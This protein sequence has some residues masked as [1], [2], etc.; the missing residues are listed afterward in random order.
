MH[1]EMHLP[2]KRL[3][4]LKCEQFF[5]HLVRSCGIERVKLEAAPLLKLWYFAYHECYGGDIDVFE[6]SVLKPRVLSLMRRRPII[7]NKI[8]RTEDRVMAHSKS[9]KTDN[10]RV[11]KQNFM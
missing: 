5:W 9:K 4:C 11:A 3:S 1:F 10:P 2:L 6:K 7:L 8:S